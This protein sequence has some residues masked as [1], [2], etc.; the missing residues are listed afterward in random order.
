MPPAQNSTILRCSA[1]RPARR[2]RRSQIDEVFSATPLEPAV[3]HDRGTGHGGTAELQL[4]LRAALPSGAA[5]ADSSRG[6]DAAALA[7]GCS[8]AAGAKAAMVITAHVK[9]GK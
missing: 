4:Q 1:A 3:R 9:F 5:L 7:G 6:Q 2:R 8:C